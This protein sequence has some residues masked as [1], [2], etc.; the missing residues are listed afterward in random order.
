MRARR[1][2]SRKLELCPELRGLIEGRAWRPLPEQIAGWLRLAY[3][4]N[5][6]MQVSRETI[7]CAFYVQGEE[8]LARAHPPPEKGPLKALCPLAVLK[9]LRPGKA[10]RH[11]VMISG[12]PA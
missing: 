6:A 10:H 1:P 2:R 8:R 5:E 12:V 9:A 4:D 11:G 7:Y 3:P